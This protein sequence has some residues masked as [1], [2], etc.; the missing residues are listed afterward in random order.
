MMEKESVAE[1]NY[2]SWLDYA[3]LDAALRDELESIAGNADE[4]EDRFYK[5]LEFGTG[6]LR[7][8][9]G[10]G[11]NRINIYT[12]G[13][14]TQGLA[15]YILAGHGAG[16]DGGKN[17]GSLS[18]AIA[19]D[20]RY[21]SPEFALEAALVFAGNGIT[22]FLFESLRP[23]PELSFAVRELGACGGVVVTASHNPPEYNGYKVYGADGGQLVPDQANQVIAKIKRVAGF[24]QVCRMDKEAA[25][26]A[27]LLRWL[28]E[29][30]DGKFTSAVLAVSPRC[31]QILLPDKPLKVVYTPLHGAGNLP[32]RRLLAELKFAEVKV[33]KEQELPDPQ[34]S[35]VKSPNPEEREAFTI[36]LQLA[37][38]EQSDLL[39]GTDPDCDR[40]GAVVRDG[41][42]DYHILNGNQTGALLVDY[43]LGSWL[44]QGKLPANG[45]VIKTIVTSEM[46][47]TIARSYGMGTMDTLTGFKYIGECMT[48][49]ERN[50]KH[51]FLFGYEESYG[52]LAGNYCR[53]KDAVVA[54]MLIA[55]AAAYY[56]SQGLTLLD[57]LERLY[58]KH[59]YF[60]ESLESLTLKGKEGVEQIQ[61]TM[62]RWRA[63]APRQVN[64]SN[65]VAVE[66]YLP[67]LNQLPKE[68]VLKYKLDDG[69]WFCLR[70]SGTEPKLKV[71]FGVCCE[72]AESA[73]EKLERL[74]RE[75]M[76]KVRSGI[77]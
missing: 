68:N 77:R 36:A 16:Q 7:G 39:I 32:V 70:P 60:L 19:Y 57:A 67:G 33:V 56:K 72:S 34:F 45:V 30:M 35:T 74:A 41:Q 8:V 17:T 49:F 21:Q 2:R 53:D 11:T 15:Q 73:Q 13:R 64:G 9:I 23:T 24:D 27:G 66:D 3:S 51:Q 58:L 6:G 31:G 10:A 46:G 47:A 1:R 20:S 65:I 61:A 48:Q 12:V 28:G 42:G 22:A 29:D 63:N 43:L 5:D 71:Y 62:E 26:D 75:V 54:S 40:M 50:G 38:R 55:E 52:Y 4:I 59:G 14:T 44:E 25:E 18:V 76:G 69:S 37:E